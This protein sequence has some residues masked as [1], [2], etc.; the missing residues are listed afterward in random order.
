MPCAPSN[1]TRFP[2]AI[3]SANKQRRIANQRPDLRGQQFRLAANGS[4]IVRD[5]Q[6]EGVCQGLLVF[7]QS[8]VELAETGWIVE[9]RDADAAAADFI[10]VTRPDPARGG[11]QRNAVLARFRHLFHQPVKREDHMRAIADPQLRLHIN[12]SRFEHGHF[13]GQGCQIHH[14]AIADHCDHARAQNPARDQLENELLLA[15]KYG[16]PGV[17]AALIPRHDIEAFGQ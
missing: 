10:L 5:L 4:V 8:I 14:H 13:L 17:M 7:G 12:P 9:I 16:M 3:A 11:A 6:V 1:R 2:A 15:D